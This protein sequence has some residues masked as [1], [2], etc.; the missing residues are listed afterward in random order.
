VVILNGMR[1]LGGVSTARLAGI[2]AARQRY[3]L[4]T[5]DPHAGHVH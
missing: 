3:G 2:A 4:G 1:L 5:E